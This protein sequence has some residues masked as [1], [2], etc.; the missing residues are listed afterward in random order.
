MELINNISFSHHDLDNLIMDEK[1]KENGYKIHYVIDAFD[2]LE[3][4]F[5]K[6]IDLDKV[7]DR[8][9]FQNNLMGYYYLFYETLPE[10][11]PIL[12][13]EYLF[14]INRNRVR[15]V[16]KHSS[17][18]QMR[19]F[20][21]D[22]PLETEEKGTERKSEIYDRLTTDVQYLIATA[23]FNKDS[24]A[25]FIDIMK[26]RVLYRRPDRF[27]SKE[28]EC[29]FL[30]FDQSRPTPKAK[31]AFNAWFEEEALNYIGSPSDKLLHEFEASMR[32]FIAIER[33]I[34][35]NRFIEKSEYPKNIFLYF[36]NSPRTTR[37]FESKYFANWYKD[38]P[39]LNNPSYSLRRNIKDV[40]LLFLLN[41]DSKEASVLQNLNHIKS[42][43]IENEQNAVINPIDWVEIL[44]NRQAAILTNQSI[45]SKLLLNEVFREKAELALEEI[46]RLW[47][48]PNKNIKLGVYF[49]KELAEA[50]NANGDISELKSYKDLGQSIS[51]QG[52]PSDL[53]RQILN[54]SSGNFNRGG[55][56]YI[57]GT[58]HKLPIL[59]FHNDVFAKR[60]Q[61]NF[62]FVIYDRILASITRSD[63]EISSTIAEFRDQL[64]RLLLHKQELN[65]EF[66]GDYK[67]IS[68]FL[69]VLIFDN[70]EAEESILNY[71]DSVPTMLE[72]TVFKSEVLDKNLSIKYV[73]FDQKKS[74]IEYLYLK[75]WL[76][77]RC[78]KYELSFQCCVEGI[79][80]APNDA[81]FYHGLA[82]INF[83]RYQESRSIESPQLKEVEILIEMIQK[84]VVLYESSMK[85]ELDYLVKGTL[86]SAKNMLRYLLLHD[87]LNYFL[88]NQDDSRV[89]LNL[90]KVEELTWQM[91]DFEGGQY[92]SQ[93]EVELTNRITTIVNAI[94]LNSSQM[95]L[96]PARLTKD[97]KVF[98]GDREQ[99]LRF[100]QKIIEKLIN[101][102][103]MR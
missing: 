95:R 37:I 36:S 97:F 72:K 73:P 46:K 80:K 101:R 92:D 29:V 67:L 52:R 18:N 42:L 63:I 39:L 12:L 26:N 98:L 20:L 35:A 90:K 89:H 49:E 74:Y 53:V 84:T 43:L 47:D 11:K 76:A 62:P 102:F 58:F 70:S 55:R 23:I 8:Q 56:D 25:T 40:I 22:L 28:S 38:N 88:Y 2:F 64:S 65:D 19:N 85:E 86:F 7:I 61:A 59:L 68:I 44:K 30:A 4:C 96:Q 75:A 54:K 48:V 33:I 83:C 45:A 60:D 9:R 5:P 50:I 27:P 24:I 32:D 100:D 93:F 82:L 13:D 34:N 87:C 15:F 16:S 51:L 91:Q 10:N 77:R 99:Y 17:T 78:A 69:L 14:E 3:Y 81:R 31:A 21:Y 66:E 79:D 57:T 1:Y 94:F 103:S 41:F 71:M 6:G